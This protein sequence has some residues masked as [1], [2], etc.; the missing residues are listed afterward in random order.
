MI[1]GPG[2]APIPPSVWASLEADVKQVLEEHFV[3]RRVVDFDGPHGLAHAAQNL[4]TLE[5]CEVA[6]GVRAGLRAVLPLLEVRVPFDLEREAIDACE[7]GAPE[8]DDD[9]A[10]AAARKLAELEDTA[11]FYGLE[12][13]HIRGQLPASSH[14]RIP[15]GS[16][17]TSA[18]DAVTRA[19]LVLDEAAVGGPYALV[20]GDA[21][22]R[23]LAA[24]P[25]YPPLKKLRDL[26][27]GGVHH[28]SVLRG[29]VLLSLRGGDYRLSVGQDAAIG[30]ASHDAGK[31]SLYLI[32]SFT[33][34]VTSPQA[35]VGL[36]E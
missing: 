8:L 29:G 10:L 26:V 33:F 13:A 7:R 17:A 35:I 9:Q 21:T 18:I 14:P 16:D 30:Y 32:E 4:G 24:S 23:R 6:T 12:A 3:G 36:D 5:P 22:Y 15:L 34:L 31:V 1:T 20:L 19:L 25:D 28:S 2:R 27:G 11:I